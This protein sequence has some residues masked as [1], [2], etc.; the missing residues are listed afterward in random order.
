MTMHKY[1]RAF[2]Q[3]VKRVGIVENARVQQSAPVLFSKAYPSPPQDIAPTVSTTE[4][5]LLV[6]IPRSFCTRIIERPHRLLAV[7]LGQ[8]HASRTTDT[9]PGSHHNLLD[10]PGCCVSLGLV[11]IKQRWIRSRRMFVK[12][13]KVIMKQ[14]CIFRVFLRSLCRTVTVLLSSNDFGC[15]HLVFSVEHP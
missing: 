5:K 1:V 2:G 4:Q 10:Q 8:S 9:P 15:S 6:V 13:R 3:H 14:R 7:N 12:T 11:N